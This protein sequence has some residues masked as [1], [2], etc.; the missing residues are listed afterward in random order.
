[1]NNPGRK[2]TSKDPSPP[3]EIVRERQKE[4][5]QRGIYWSPLGGLQIIA[6]GLNTH[7]VEYATA[8]REWEMVEEIVKAKSMPQKMRLFEELAKKYPV[9]LTVRETEKSK[10]PK[11]N[12][13]SNEPQGDVLK[14]LWWS[15]FRD[16]AWKRL[17]RCPQCKDWFVDTT[18]NRSAIRCSVY[19]NSRWWSR[20]RRKK[21]NHT[22]SKNE[23]SSH[24]TEKREG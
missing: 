2:Q 12:L 1:M 18:R 16:E 21:A 8:E 19:C 14:Q 4:Q 10:L 17:Q 15:Y 24:G 7:N 23:G 13:A 22:L 3:R 6:T 20:D 11:P 5:R 9:C